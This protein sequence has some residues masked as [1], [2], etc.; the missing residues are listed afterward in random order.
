MSGLQRFSYLLVRFWS[1]FGSRTLC[2]P[3]HPCLPVEESRVSAQ[4]PVPPPLP[5]DRWGAP[6]SDGHRGWSRSADPTARL[7]VTAAENTRRV[8]TGAWNPGKS[9]N[10][11]FLG[12]GKCLI[13]SFSAWKMNKPWRRLLR[14]PFF[15]IKRCVLLYILNFL[16]LWI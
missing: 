13:F 8:P 12:S 16:L 11:M 5:T 9:L 10:V 3:P 4:H 6:S 2:Y 15:W 7:Q 1:D 14:V